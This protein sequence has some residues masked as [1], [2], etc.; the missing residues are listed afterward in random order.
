MLHHFSCYLFIIF[1]ADPANVCHINDIKLRG[2]G[3]RKPWS[4]VLKISNFFGKHMIGITVMRNPDTGADMQRQNLYDRVPS[5]PTCD[6]SLKS[7][8]GRRRVG[9]KSSR[10]KVAVALLR[11]G[12]SQSAA[13][14]SKNGPKIVQI[15]LNFARS[16]FQLIVYKI[17]M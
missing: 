15:A 17:Q 2:A 9:G 16:V 11:D 5:F 6:C 4:C 1:F 12:I 13:I 10:G 8:Q 3:D 7:R 14:Q